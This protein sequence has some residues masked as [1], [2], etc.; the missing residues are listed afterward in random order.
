MAQILKEQSR[1]DIIEAA[2]EEFLEKGYKD[3][4]LRSIAKKAH[5]TVGNLYRYFKNKEDINRH[6]VGPTLSLLE[7]MLGELTDN[8]V[9]FEAHVFNIKMDKRELI[10]KLDALAEKMVD[11]YEG[12]RIEFNILMLR[13]KLND[14]ITN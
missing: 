12:H 6:I 14:D 1:N 7:K 3:A 5:M 8:K 2:K 11:I 4:S 13:S 9:S 10:E